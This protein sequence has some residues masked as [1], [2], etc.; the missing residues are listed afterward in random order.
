MA[1]VKNVISKVLQRYININLNQNLN[2]NLSFS[3]NLIYIRE[4]PGRKSKCIFFY[5]QRFLLK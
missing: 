4:T 1:K 5:I 2:L 3:L